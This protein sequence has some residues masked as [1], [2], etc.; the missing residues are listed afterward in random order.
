MTVEELNTISDGLGQS[1]FGER[2]SEGFKVQL[3]DKVSIEAEKKL[4]KH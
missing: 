4:T 1:W 3:K 2:C